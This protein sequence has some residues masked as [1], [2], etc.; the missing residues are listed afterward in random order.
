M[1]RWWWILVG[2]AACDVVDP[3][4]GLNADLR[5][6]WNS[7]GIPMAEDLK[8]YGIGSCGASPEEASCVSDCYAD[9]PCGAL[10]DSDPDAA[11]ALSA[12]EQGC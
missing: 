5:D 6:K 9:A 7:C 12:C 8:D 3:C 2:V 4:L 1:G 10:D 11:D